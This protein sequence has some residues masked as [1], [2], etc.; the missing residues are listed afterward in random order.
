MIEHPAATRAEKRL[1]I[2]LVGPLPPP[3]GGI[4]NQTEQLARLLGESGLQVDVVRVNAPYRPAWIDRM[5]GIRAI[6]RLLPYMERLWR[7]AVQVDLFHV[8]A[9]SGWAWHLFAAPAIW[10]AHLRRVPVI[11]NYRGG[12]AERFLA[13]QHRWVLPTLRRAAVVIVPSG[14][15]RQVFAKWSIATEIVPNIIDLSRFSPGQPDPQRLHFLVSRNLEDIY[16]I[17]TAIVAFS[18]VRRRHPHARLTVAGSGPKGAELRALCR[19]LD[20][21]EAVEF[22][23]QLDNARMAE[24][25]RTADIA[26][27]PTRADNMPISLLEAMASGTPIVTTDVGGIPFLAEHE[28]TALLVP[29]GNPEAMAAAAFRLIDDPALA[30]RLRAEGQRTATSYSWTNVRPRLLS[31]YAR[32]LGSA[33]PLG[34]VDI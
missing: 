20:L 14:F 28:R 29:P 9:N 5:R 7:V 33:E 2:A 15:L 1:R 25:Y 17:P 31:A 6:F 23:G 24:V 26:L 3:P 27:N 10:I 34:S 18:I 16:D 12:G 4:A 13:R 21:H 30:A 19:Q 32:V 22:A 8:M 11:V